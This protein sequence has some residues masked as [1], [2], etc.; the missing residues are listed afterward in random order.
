MNWLNFT[1]RCTGKAS[2][3]IQ[4]PFTAF[5]ELVKRVLQRNL[6]HAT[7]AITMASLFG[8][9]QVMS[10]PS[11]NHWLSSREWRKCIPNGVD[12]RDEKTHRDIAAYAKRWLEDP[13]VKKWLIVFDNVEDVSDIIPFVPISSPS[14]H[15]LFTTRVAV[16]LKRNDFFARSFEL[17]SMEVEDAIKLLLSR[18]LPIP[19]ATE[20]EEQ[21]AKDIIVE[22]DCLAL[23]IHQAGSYILQSR[24]KLIDF[25]PEY[26]AELPTYL[27]VRLTGD[28]G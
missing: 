4:S 20:E 2:L 16:N 10:N 24:M 28:A 6:P 9:L 26:K 5:R 12:V 25:L 14:K 7:R 1:P 17:S 11:S 23:A 15:A 27:R 3:L 13:D 18:A 21:C 22:F 19:Q 8:F